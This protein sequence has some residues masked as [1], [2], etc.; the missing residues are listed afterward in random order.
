MKLS[1][2]EIELLVEGLD[3]VANSEVKK[4]D[5]IKDTKVKLDKL[6]VIRGLL[7][8]LESQLSGI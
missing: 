1:I 7:D 6:T 5:S 3:L 2:L 4:L 8:K